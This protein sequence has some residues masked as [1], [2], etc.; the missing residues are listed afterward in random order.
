M[1]AKKKSDDQYC[2][3]AVTRRAVDTFI[4]VKGPFSKAQAYVVAAHLERFEG[5]HCQVEEL[6]SLCE[7]NSWILEGVQ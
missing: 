2:V 4:D 6:E 1:A 5:Q 7:H 3:V